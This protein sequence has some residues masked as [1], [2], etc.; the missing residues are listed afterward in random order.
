MSRDLDSSPNDIVVL[1]GI[2]LGSFFYGYIVTQ[3]PGGM[4]SAKYGAKWVFGLGCLCTT[5]L[6]LL[7]PI[8]A[9]QSTWLLIVVRI[10]EGLGEVPAKGRGQFVALVR[11]PF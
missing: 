11:R 9:Y 7:T 5:V 6:T 10:L 4:L 8:A 2:I 1:A 3:I